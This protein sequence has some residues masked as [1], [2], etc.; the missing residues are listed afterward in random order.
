MQGWVVVIVVLTGSRTVSL[1]DDVG[2]ASLVAD[3]A[4]QMHGLGGVILGEGLNLTTMTGST[5]LGV[6]GHG[7]MARRGE[8]AMR[9]EREG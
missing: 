6:E 1:T 7:A 4:G 8:L 9:L 3:E 2:H 5:L